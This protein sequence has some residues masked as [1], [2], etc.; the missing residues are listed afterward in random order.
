MLANSIE[1]SA[2]K[3]KTRRRGKDEKMKRKSF[4]LNRLKTARKIRL[5]KNLFPNSFSLQQKPSKQQ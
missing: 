1:L 4:W 2:K 5:F 3:R